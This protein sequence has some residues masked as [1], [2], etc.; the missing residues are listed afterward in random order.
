MTYIRQSNHDIEDFF[1]QR[2]SPRS[3][4][5]AII[6][7]AT[8]Q[9]LFEAARWAPSAWNS[10]PWRFIYA[11]KDTPHWDNI[12]ATLSEYNQSWAK[13]ASALIVVISKTNF[14]VPG[15]NTE[16]ELRSHAF[17]TGAAW[18]HLAI[19]ADLKGWKTHAIG[20]YDQDQVRH[21][22]DIPDNY[23]IQAIIV[24]GK[25]GDKDNLPDHLQSR[26]F[27]STR[28]PT[29]QFTYEGKFSVETTF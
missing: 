24:L 5:P 20:G 11:R 3:F 6:D 18:S 28:H 9:Q 27:P 21:N 17:D 15:Q 2:W 19:Q 29:E 1:L 14:L 7:Q 4:S 10:Q 8:L 22:L 12:F 13:D 23:A 16:Q 26:E 25:Q